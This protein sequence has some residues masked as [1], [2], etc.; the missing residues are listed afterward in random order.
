MKS[1]K[2]AG[3]ITLEVFKE[4]YRRLLDAY[5]GPRFVVDD[6]LNIECLRIRHFYFAFYVYKYATGISA[7]LSLAERVLNGR[8]DELEAYLGFLK[9]GGQRFPIETLRAA[10]VDMLSP[11]PIEKVMNLFQTRIRQLRELVSHFG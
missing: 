11:E 7:A 8:S 1:R 5:F 9:A 6:Q 4:T 3:P 2:T 10:G